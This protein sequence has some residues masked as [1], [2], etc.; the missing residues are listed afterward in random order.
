MDGESATES[1]AALAREN[2][3]DRLSSAVGAVNG[4]EARTGSG[5]S[6]APP[7][8]FGGTGVGES[9]TKLVLA[10]GFRFGLSPPPKKL[11]NVPRSLR[12]I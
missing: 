2:G 1:K 4:V 11:F 3:A 6:F 12:K 9:E 5:P 10:E 7:G 8:L